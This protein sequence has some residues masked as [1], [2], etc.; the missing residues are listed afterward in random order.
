M[1]ENIF[2]VL[3]YIFENY[4]DDDIELL[5][6]SDDI[7]TELIQAGFEHAEVNNA[8][9]WLEG[10]TEQS[11]MQ[12][13]I[14]STFRIFTTQEVIK[15]DIECRNF[16][17]SLEHTGI[18][19]P[20]IREIVIDRAMAI[21]NESLSLDELKW[22]ILMVLLSQSDDDIAFSRMEDIVYDLT[23]ALLH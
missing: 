14:A 10:L 15:L 2:D 11:I 12:P 17:L 8:F 20:A 9:D 13:S 6:D 23:P 19:T 7:K 16:L 18:L 21:E 4:L 3:I 22:T 1:K 5:P